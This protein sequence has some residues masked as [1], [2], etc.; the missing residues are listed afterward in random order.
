LSD[1]EEESDHE[2]R[3]VGPGVPVA[4]KATSK[5]GIQ[6]FSFGMKAGDSDSSEEE[7]K[8]EER[9]IQEVSE[10]QED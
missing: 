7:N 2:Y 6:G 1:S 3:N 10:D 9:G 4:P 8:S 5:N